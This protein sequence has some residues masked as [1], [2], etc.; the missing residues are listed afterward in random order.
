[1][2]VARLVALAALGA[3]AAC[4]ARPDERPPLPVRV[5]AVLPFETAAAADQ[6][7]K[8]GEN[9]PGDVVTAQVYRV[10]AE[11]TEYDVVPDLTAVSYTHLT[12]PRIER[13]R[14]RWSPYH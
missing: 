3:L 10:L 14:S 11:Q 9:T 2:R 12:L 4:G 13:C 6:G 7:G 1:M 5:L 8:R